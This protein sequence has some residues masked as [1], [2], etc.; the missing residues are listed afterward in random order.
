MGRLLLIGRWAAFDVCAIY[1]TKST[2]KER[3]E[4]AVV[5]DLTGN[6]CSRRGQKYILGVEWHGGECNKDFPEIPSNDSDDVEYMILECTW[7]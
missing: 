7:K 3:V 6:G 5:L 2:G 4:F 1:G